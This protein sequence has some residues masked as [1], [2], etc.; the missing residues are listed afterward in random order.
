MSIAGRQIL[1][2]T[3]IVNEAIEECRSCKWKGIIFKIDLRRFM[4]TWN[5]LDKVLAKKKKKKRF[6]Y[7]RGIGFGVGLDQSS[8]RS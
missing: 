4:T 1:D 6:G 2:Q 8:T 7:I 3:L 5:F